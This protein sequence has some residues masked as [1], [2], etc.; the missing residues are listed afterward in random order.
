MQHGLVDVEEDSFQGD[1]TAR[2]R[3]FAKDR[4]K[5]LFGLSQGDLGLLALRNIDGRSFDQ[6]ASVRFGDDSGPLQYPEE[7]S[8]LTALRTFIV[9]HL[10]LSLQGLHESGARGRL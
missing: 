3:A 4:G 10:A 1:Q 7:R 6:A 9:Q 8:V 5:P 2:Y